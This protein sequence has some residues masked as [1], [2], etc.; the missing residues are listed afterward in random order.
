MQISQ[1]VKN[2]KINI[3]IGAKHYYHFIYGSVIR[4][5][6]NGPIAVESL[7]GWVLIGYYDKISTTNNSNAT[8]MLYVNFEISEHSNDDYKH[9]EKSFKLWQWC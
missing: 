1:T 4:G 6:I 7:F 3:L 9:Y 2:R 5:K 8:H